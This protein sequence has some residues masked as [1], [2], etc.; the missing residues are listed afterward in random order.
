MIGG[1]ALVVT[2]VATALLALVVLGLIAVVVGVSGIAWDVRRWRT[3]R[4]PLPPS[5]DLLAAIQVEKRENYLGSG[6]SGDSVDPA[7]LG[8]TVRA[9][10]T[11]VRDCQVRL[12]ALRHLPQ[13]ASLRDIEVLPGPFAWEDDSTSSTLRPG[14][15]RTIWLVAWRSSGPWLLS[16][17]PKNLSNPGRYSLQ[18]EIDAEGYS[19]A[20]LVFEFDFNRM[21][22]NWSSLG[23]A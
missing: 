1:L 18:I 15:N 6:D 20:R 2:G 13:N 21:D 23:W 11:E 8:L 16:A 10:D 4:G 17:N 19:V 5:R 12:V 14:G 3:S 22:A 9:I 7:R